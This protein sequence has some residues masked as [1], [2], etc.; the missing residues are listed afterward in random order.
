MKRLRKN[1]LTFLAIIAVAF[2][3]PACDDINSGTNTDDTG[4]GSD[5]PTVQC[6]GYTNDGTRCERKTSNCSGYCWQ[7][8]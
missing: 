3:V 8:D 5:C 6:S 4:G 7:H 2:S 1:I